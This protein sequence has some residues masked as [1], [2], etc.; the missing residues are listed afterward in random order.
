MTDNVSNNDLKTS[1]FKPHTIKF[2]LHRVAVFL[3][4]SFS[5]AICLFL[6]S[7]PSIVADKM[8]I[9]YEVN[10]SDIGIFTSIYFYT[11]GVVQPFVGLSVDV[12]EPGFIIGGSLFVASI[13]TFISGAGKTL[14][15]GCIG[16][17]LVGF[18]CGPVYVSV[19]RCLINWFD[20]HSYPLILGI[21]H[22]IGSLGYLGAQGP[23][24]YMAGAIGWRM[25]FYSLGIAGFVFCILSFIFVR[26]NPVVF[27]YLPVN[28]E[29]GKNAADTPLKEK[30]V[31]LF[32]NFKV[33]IC[34]Y[35]LWLCIIYA[36]LTNGPF[37]DI[38][39]MWCT[40]FLEDVF[41]YS[42]KKAGN[43]MMSMT[44]SG[45]IGNVAIAPICYLFKTR[46][47]VLVVTAIL[48]AA[49]TVIFVFVKEALSLVVV[50]VIFFF[51]AFI[52]SNCSVL[53][54]LAVDYF[55]HKIAGSAVGL[56][57]MFLFIIS[58]VYIAISSKI[59]DIYGKVPG[60]EK[61]TFEGYKYG[62]WVFNTASYALGGVIGLFM[63]EEKFAKK[64]EGDK[65]LQSNSTAPLLSV[66]N[67]E[68]HTFT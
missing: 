13:G 34:S 57:N 11:Y 16:R 58:A 55:D 7:C 6:R 9:D 8:A 61:Y 39:G 42:D 47:W 67:N 64:K 27:K 29:L 65:Q 19:N 49:V 62:L 2:Q 52:G 59:L 14:L 36:I 60:T 51:Y 15:I 12:A 68:N 46:K 45:I 1:S 4:L 30:F 31:I 3:L 63:K 32:K 40:Q 5:Y 18:G 26:G 23:L 37:Y 24:A 44:I 17:A 21:V 38:N 35:H 33:V 28:A 53:Y 48:C 50:C 56:M 22:S 54:S 20:V 25:S 43:T 66:D 10:K 41:D